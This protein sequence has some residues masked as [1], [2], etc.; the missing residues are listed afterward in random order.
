MVLKPF[1]IPGKIASHICHFK[2]QIKYIYLLRLPTLIQFAAYFYLF[3]ASDIC[4]YCER[5]D[6]LRL[7]RE[8]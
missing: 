5:R 4:P 2:P 7:C 3:G 6:T 1:S 8:H